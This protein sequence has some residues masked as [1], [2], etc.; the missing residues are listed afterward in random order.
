MGKPCRLS[1]FAFKNGESVFDGLGDGVLDRFTIANLENG[2]DYCEWLISEG[3]E[4][5]PLD[6]FSLQGFIEWAK[7]ACP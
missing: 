5:E 3:F 6:G 2:I 1:F 7:P 4:H